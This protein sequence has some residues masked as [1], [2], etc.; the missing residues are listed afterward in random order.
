MMPAHWRLAELTAK[1]VLTEDEEIEMALILRFNRDCAW[2]LAEL[3][4][5]SLM[6]TMIDDINWQHEI[7][8]QIDRLEIEFKTTKRPQ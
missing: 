8:A 6:A 3:Y 5:W 1:V 7:C 4:N 2:K